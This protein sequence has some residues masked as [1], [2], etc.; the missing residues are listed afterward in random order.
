M[1]KYIDLCEYLDRMAQAGRQRATAPMGEHP[2]KVLEANAE[3]LE[4]AAAAIRELEAERDMLRREGN[5]ADHALVDRYR[6]TKTGIFKFPD[7]V[8][9][10]IRRLDAA[11]AKV[12]RL[13]GTAARDVLAE[14][15]R[16]VEAEGWTTERDD[17]YQKGELA[18]AAG[19]YALASTF[20]HADPYAA[21]LTIW[22]WSRSWL[23]PTNPRRDLVKAGALIIAEI[24]R[25]DRAALK[26]TTP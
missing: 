4:Q 11:E 24:E 21:V 3:R 18:Q 8:A 17:T 2:K 22:P 15:A 6:N 13:E 16:Q 19:A 5:P 14:R 20:Y 25:L 23:K 9:A 26:G 7:D 1:T 10:I 12:A